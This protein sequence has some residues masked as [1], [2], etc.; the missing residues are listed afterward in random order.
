VHHFYV[1]VGEE[2]CCDSAC[3]AIATSDSVVHLA[4]EGVLVQLL[5]CTN[6][7]VPYSAALGAT[8]GSDSVRECLVWLLYVFARERKLVQGRGRGRVATS[9][10]VLALNPD[11]EGTRLSSLAAVSSFDAS[12][13]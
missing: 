13:L 2:G 5:Q 12:S 8:I 3:P 1:G 9:V 10:V 4:R 6:T 7:L 11:Q